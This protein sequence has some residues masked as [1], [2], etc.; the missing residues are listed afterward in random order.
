V[1]RLHAALRFNCG[2]DALDFR[3]RARNDGHARPLTRECERHGAADAP[4]AARDE[5]DFTLKP[6]RFEFQVSGFKFQDCQDFRF[7]NLKPET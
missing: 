3:R 1:H 7:F 5:C 2:G 6:H 4:T